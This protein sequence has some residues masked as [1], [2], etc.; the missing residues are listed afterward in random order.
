MAQHSY[1]SGEE[2]ISRRSESKSG[3]KMYGAWFCPYVQ[4]VWASLEEKGL[5]YQWNEVDPYSA[6]APGSRSNTKTA[7][8]LDEK[9]Q[10]CE[11]HTPVR[12]HSLE[13]VAAF[14]VA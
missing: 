1:P 9:R 11:S 14:F 8:S 7:L 10:R 12:H 4:R 2:T 13:S 5:D 6:L 3:L